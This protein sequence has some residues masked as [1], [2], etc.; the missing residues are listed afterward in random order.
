MGGST[1]T[2]ASRCGRH[3]EALHPQATR[4]RGR[5]KGQGETEK[6]FI[7]GS[8]SLRQEPCARSEDIPPDPTISKRVPKEVQ[9]HVITTRHP[10]LNINYPYSYKC[11]M[12]EDPAQAPMM[13]WNSGWN[14]TEGSD[15]LSYFKFLV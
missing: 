1:I 3:W 13:N 2:I 5:T 15:S 10:Q 9:D 7:K 4:T 12:P 6:A 8:L 11:P 14:P